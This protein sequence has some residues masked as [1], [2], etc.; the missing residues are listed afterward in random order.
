[1][2][3]LHTDREYQAELNLLKDK[4]ISMGEK[5]RQMIHSCL[6]AYIQRDIRTAEI[7]LSLEKE[8]NRL[9]IEID[10]L[11]FS[12][13]AKRQPVASDL[14]L[15]MSILKQVPNLERIGDLAETVALRTLDLR[16]H[17]KFSLPDKL[18]EIDL[19]LGRMM[20]GALEA[21]IQKNS[22]LSAK[23]I[24]MDRSVDVM[25]AE[26]FRDILKRIEK[27]PQE[28][29]TAMNLH[30]VVTC[31]ERIGDHITNLAEMNIYMIEGRDIRHLEARE[32]AARK[33]RG[34]L[35]L[36]VH[37]SA[38]SQMAE[39]WARNLLPKEIAVFSAGSDPADRVHPFAIKVMGEV[40]IDISGYRPKKISDIPIENIDVV[41]TL[42]SEEICIDLPALRK[43]ET[44][45]IEDPVSFQGSP[46][47]IQKKFEKVR[48]EIK[49]RV[50]A[51]I[52]ELN[53]NLET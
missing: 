45:F 38:R 31:L 53:L 11:C 46:E 7:V 41:I 28:T 26:I 9:E 15:V 1:M 47:E 29:F 16:D 24:S 33:V 18:Q 36:C 19:L 44:W 20:V 6:Q 22:E 25:C 10:E 8:V 32:A 52:R 21:F 51:L 50:E 12:I 35:F 27:S 37:N 3:T 34:I 5:V 43:S 39:G 23:I 40:G 30:T 4:T 14:R 42:C 48:D 17:P 2:S 49:F 13:L